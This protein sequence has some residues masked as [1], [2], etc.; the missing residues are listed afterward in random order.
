MEDNKDS[1][2]KALYCFTCKEIESEANNDKKHEGHKKVYYNVE[3]LKKGV[4]RLIHNFNNQKDKWHDLEKEIGK[5]K[6]ETNGL[7]KKL[8]EEF[9][10]RLN[11]LV[12]SEFA[13]LINEMENFIGDFKKGKNSEAIGIEMI[14]KVNEK[15]RKLQDDRACVNLLKK[16]L[17]NLLEN[18]EKDKA[19]FKEFLSN[20][21]SLIKEEIDTYLFSKLTKTE[22]YAE[23]DLRNNLSI[24]LSVYTMYQAKLK[25][26]MHRV[27]IP[28]KKINHSEPQDKIHIE[29][30]D[31]NAIQLEVLKEISK[32]Y[33]QKNEKLEKINEE[34]EK[35]LKKHEEKKNELVKDIED[36]TKSKE[37]IEKERKDATKKKEKIIEELDKKYKELNEQVETLENKIKDMETANEKKEKEKEELERS[38]SELKNNKASYDD[39]CEKLKE[40]IK[41]YKEDEAKAKE[42]FDKVLGDGAKKLEET[43]ES[44]KSSRAEDE[45]SN[46]TLR[47][48][49]TKKKAKLKD[50]DKEYES[51]KTKY[52]D[53][54]KSMG[55]LEK[56]IKEV[57]GEAVSI[58][59]RLKEK[60]SS[61]DAQ[62]KEYKAGIKENR[63]E[64]N[65]LGK[66]KVELA[67]ELKKAEGDISKAQ[68]M[69]NPRIIIQYL[70]SEETKATSIA[71]PKAY[72]SKATQSLIESIKK[73]IFN[74][75]VSDELAKKMPIK[76]ISFVNMFTN[77][78]DFIKV[79]D[80][81]TTASCND[82]YVENE[83]SIMEKGIFESLEK[84]SKSLRNNEREVKLCIKLKDPDTKKL[85]KEVEEFNNKQK[86]LKVLLIS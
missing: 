85:E 23:N 84:I 39:K 51:L 26:A 49:I 57:K 44:A 33:K 35:K 82:I 12:Q 52:D 24:M 83:K 79:L 28:P 31:V 30:L 45:Q 80:A 63:N 75:S 5:L 62:L 34:L 40:K 29:E 58:E 70:P 56:K 21:L 72:D 68:D 55:E 48:E 17:E 7:L 32:E 3:E 46:N 53:L 66:K 25:K 65:D 10:K 6:E 2:K 16:D 37:E 81:S 41:K 1:N 38:C 15:I 20:A 9:N 8:Q 4:N 67:R 43:K 69:L 86:A 78:K 74:A 14:E 18:F 64:Y 19:P 73:N 11:S 13:N 47:E 60:Q 50:L 54:L 36:Q 27:D 77:Q 22:S 59:T 76:Y 42:S 71:A 61:F